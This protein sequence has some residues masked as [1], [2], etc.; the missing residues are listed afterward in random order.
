VQVV[1]PWIYWDRELD[2]NSWSPSD[3]PQT[4]RVEAHLYFGMLSLILVG[5]TLWRRLLFQDR[6]LLVW[7]LLGLLALSY[8]FG[9]YLPVA[10]HLPGF[11]FFRGEGRFGLITTMSVALL[12]GA[13]LTD[14]CAL[15]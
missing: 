4:N 9:W 5:W 2:L 15:R 8:T 3:A 6:R 7:A 14:L 1:T 13:G 10:K 11:S 12:A